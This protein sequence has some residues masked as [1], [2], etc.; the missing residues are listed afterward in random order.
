MDLNAINAI[1]IDFDLGTSI[2]ENM[3]QDCVC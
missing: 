1:D 3:R 2:A